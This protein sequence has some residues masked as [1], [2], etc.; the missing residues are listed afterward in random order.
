MRQRQL[1]LPLLLTI[2]A[3]LNFVQ[4]YFVVYSVK[5]IDSKDEGG[6]FREKGLRIHNYYRTLNKA[7]PLELDHEVYSFTHLLD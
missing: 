4:S 7:T 2:I 5:E 6:G 3:L 1:I